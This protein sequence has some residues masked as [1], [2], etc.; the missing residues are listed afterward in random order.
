MFFKKYDN[1]LTDFKIIEIL[2]FW[3]LDCL[4]KENCFDVKNSLQVKEIR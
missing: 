4:I 1:E 2:I 3:I